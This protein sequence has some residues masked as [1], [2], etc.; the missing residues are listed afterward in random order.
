MTLSGIMHLHSGQ[1]QCTAC[2]ATV[3]DSSKHKNRFLKRHGVHCKQ[4]ER[5]AFTAQLAAGTRS[6]DADGWLEDVE[7]KTG[8]Y[9]L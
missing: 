3:P 2:G 1:L 4:A 9:A 5:K 7:N 6:V 8:G